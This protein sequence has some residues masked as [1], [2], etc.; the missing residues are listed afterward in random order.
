MSLPQHVELRG[1][2]F[3]THYGVSLFLL[4][5][6]AV[7]VFAFLTHHGDPSRLPGMRVLCLITLPA[8]GLFAWYQTRVLRFRWLR[9]SSD[10][11]SNYRKVMNAMHNAGW[12]VRTHTVDSRIVATVPGTIT[13]GT[14]V[15]VR[16][17]ATD[18]LV[19]SI[20]DP[21]AWFV[22]GFGLGENVDNVRYIGQA[23][24]D[25]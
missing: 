15:E 3:V 16:F 2:D 4:M 23:V 24:A 14:R 7:L 20:C 17:H 5:P 19:N 6:S 21:T 12:H 10:A 13:W 18:V 9:T 11:S 8:A 22:S 1:G 25:I